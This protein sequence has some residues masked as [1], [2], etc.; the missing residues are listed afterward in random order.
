MNKKISLG[1][2]ISLVALACA[3][4]FILTSA[5]NL[6][7]FNQKVS[8]VEN[9]ADTYSRLSELD[10]LVRENFYTDIDETA[11]S[12]AILKGYVSGLNDP[13]SRY[14]TPQELTASQEN[15]KG[16]LVGIGV[17]VLRDESG[18][19]LIDSVTTD[20]PADQSELAAGDMIVAVNGTE[21][22]ELGYEQAVDQIRGKEGTS[23]KLT[24]RRGGVDKEYELVRRSIEVK[25]AWG[26]MLEGKIGYIRISG[27]KESTVDQFNEALRT[28]LNDGAKALVFDVRGNHGGL[29]SSVGSC[30]DPLL[31][32]GDV[33]FAT[34][35]DGSEE[36]LI[37]SDGEELELPM[38]V[39][40]DQETASAAELFA[41]ALRDFEKAKL[42]GVTTYGKGVMQN[43]I[44][45]NDGGGLTITVATYRTA[46]SACYQGV[47]LIPDYDVELPEDAPALDDLSHEEDA[48]LQKALSVL[49][50]GE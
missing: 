47:G 43:T 22:L 33:A 16:V 14:M 50:G 39:L 48:Q 36:V 26:E 6:H 28:L 38:A 20:T 44:S 3:L 8:S 31:P 15:D 45:L 10:G 18:Y 32:E 37:R 2:T 42:Y 17:N 11:L 30:L 24:V 29:V 23:L 4:T 40:V 7:H 5:Y 46:R 27:F 21:V 19:I 35:R 25:T 1:L 12:D 41:S 34:Y 9:M 13:Y 49:Q